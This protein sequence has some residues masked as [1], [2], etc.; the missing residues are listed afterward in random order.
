MNRRH[1]VQTLTTGLLLHQPRSL[2]GFGRTAV[3]KVFTVRG[4][5]SPNQLGMTL[6]HE[7]VLVDFI[8][9]DKVS[10]DRYRP[11]E[12][13]RVALPF[14]KQARELGCRTLVECTPAYLGRDPVVLKKLSEASR[15]QVLTN[16][17]YYG[18][19]DDKYVPKH[20]YQET[21]G[22]LA[23]RW[24][25]EFQHGIEGT[26]IKPGIMK[27]GVDAGPLSEID[28]KIVRAAAL[29]HLKTG[30]TIASHT[31]DG[32]AA[33]QE[34]DLLKKEGVAPSAFV[35]V[36]AQIESQTEK[37]LKAAEQGAWIEFDGISEES[38]EQHVKLVK[39]MIDRGFVGQVLISQDAGWYNVGE[40]GGGKFRDYGT[41]FNQFIPALKKSG[42]SEA[43]IQKLLV[44]NPRKALEPK[45]KT[46][47]A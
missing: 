28:A 25:R 18:A 36:H 9:A 46:Y 15:L 1:F 27:I 8:G 42:V 5:V 24:I 33:L 29:T 7:H 38:L 30:L 10:R 21:A 19:A 34:I 47:G 14:L 45:V 23:S 31:G 32:A 41:L 35:W 22:Q 26:G 44:D 12:V 20:A 40:P 3:A 13:F 37:H 17:G 43:Q 39:E 11:E 16:T 6:M 2:E 4:T